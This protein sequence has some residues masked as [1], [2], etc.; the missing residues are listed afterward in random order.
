MILDHAAVAAVA[1]M[2]PTAHHV[3][4]GVLAARVGELPE[5]LRVSGRVVVQTF[6]RRAA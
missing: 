3:E 6:G 5:P 2:G 4:A 1:A